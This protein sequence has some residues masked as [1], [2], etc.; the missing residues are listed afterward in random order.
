MW[1]KQPLFFIFFFAAIF[2]FHKKS[3]ATH[4]FGGELLYTY[5][6]DN[7]YKITLTLYGDCSA[8]IFSTLYT[9][10]AQVEIYEGNTKKDT[11]TLY[12]DLFNVKEVSPVCPNELANTACNNPA[13]PLPGVK[14]F[15]YSNTITLPHAS[16]NWR[17]IFAGSLGGAGGAGRSSQIT[18]IPQGTSMQIEATLNNLNGPNNS[19]S[20]STIPTPFYC[21]GGT[22]EYN[23]GAIDADG[24]SLAFALVPA[25]DGITASPVSY[26]VPTSADT[27]IITQPGNFNFSPING[28]LTFTAGTTQ[29]ALVVNQVYEYRHGVLVGTSKREMTFVI[30]NPCQSEAPSLHIANLTG[31][32][33]T[34]GNVIK[35]CSGTPQLAFHLSLSN[36]DNDSTDLEISSIPPGAT[37]N[38]NQNFSTTPSIDF[39][40]NTDTLTLGV[41]TFYVY[42]KNNHCPVAANRTLAY[43]INVVPLPTVSQVQIGPTGCIHQGYMQ[44]NLALGYLPRTLTIMRGTSII[45]TYTDST[46]LVQDSLAAGTYVAY[47]SS[48]PAC[49]ATDTFT[50]TDSGK[51]PLEPYSISLC[52]GDSSQIFQF[53][54]P[55]PGTVTTWYDAGSNQLPGPP[56]VSTAIADTTTWYVTEHYKVCESDKTLATAIVHPLPD[57]QIL[58]K[59]NLICYGDTIYLEASGGISYIWKPES[60]INTSLD[61]RLF[62]RMI[63]GEKYTVSTTTQYGCLDSASVVY[64]NI[65]PCCG[66]FYPNAFTPNATTNNGFRV[67]PRGNMYDYMLAVYNRW[68]QLVYLSYDPK[69]SWDGKLYGTPCEA[70]T[71]FY[72]FKARC[73]TGVME[74]KKGDVTLIR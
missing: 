50:I 18:N 34:S 48:N 3:F 72:Y 70:G 31:G 28:Q 47:A 43:T 52:K 64:D 39:S 37:L 16:A 4:I 25:V 46:G 54:E 10:S 38:I 21:L 44:Y 33:L 11:L 32:S 61:G 74:E 55:G 49:V 45:K 27:P 73:L 24:D 26:F 69:A 19:P 40:W 57:I 59:P 67:V 41:Y 66:F 13:H 22:Q 15:I 23:Q 30:T 62:A 6:S 51:L 9:S 60:Q 56:T 65:Q 42:L 36:P 71:Y 63:N 17:F 68:G 20:Y 12:V 1:K 58:N 14:R 8:Q 7:T 53:P 2:S 29:D 5:V 35:I